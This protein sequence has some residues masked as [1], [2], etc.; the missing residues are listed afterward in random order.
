M[1]RR[2]LTDVRL[3]Q[4]VGSESFTLTKNQMPAHNHTLEATSVG[5]SESEPAGKVLAEGE[6]IYG[7]AASLVDMA[8]AAVA[9]SGAS[10]SVTKRSPAQV[11]T[12]VVALQGIYCLRN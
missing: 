7:D 6:D 9:N 3:G 10:Q 5:A 8:G 1:Q 2:G 11:I 12:W 4:K